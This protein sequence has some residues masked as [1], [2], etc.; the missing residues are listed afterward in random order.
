M[1]KSTQIKSNTCIYF[2]LLTDCEPKIRAHFFLLNSYLSIFISAVSWEIS[3]SKSKQHT[4]KNQSKIWRQNSL[5]HGAEKIQ[6]LG[7]RRRKTKSV[8]CEK[9]LRKIRKLY[10]RVYLHPVPKKGEISKS[11]DENCP[12][13]GKFFFSLKLDHWFDCFYLNWKLIQT[14][15]LFEFHYQTLL[16]YNYT[17]RSSQ[18]LLEL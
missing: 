5:N 7:E 14:P 11:V 10:F 2:D 13:L 4:I 6:E 3:K 15:N 16:L 17:R 18:D 9:K 8:Q 12:L 1:S